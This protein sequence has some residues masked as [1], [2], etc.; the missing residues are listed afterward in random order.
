MSAAHVPPAQY[1]AGLP[2]SITGAGVI[3]HDDTGRFLLVRPAYRD[4]TWEIPGGGLAEGEF[5]WHAARR[6]AGEELGLDVRPGRLL[7]VD[8]VP[9]QADGR[10][11]L[12]NYLFDGG[13][14]TAGH[15]ERHVRLQTGELRE[16]RLA[17]PGE[18]DRLLIARLVRRL[19]AAGAALRT[20]AT[21]YLHDGR[22][23][24]R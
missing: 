17:G 15:A 8:W 4:D 23:P 11:A 14:I 18:W 12:A 16:W 7:V 20:G 19:H 10:P 3:L 13:R 2:R 24:G 9:P 6:E 1:Y 21:A 5:P 22:D